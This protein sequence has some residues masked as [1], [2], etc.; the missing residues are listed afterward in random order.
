MKIT[1]YVDDSNDDREAPKK[2][3]L[4]LLT[5]AFDL[6]AD[7]MFGAIRDRNGNRVRAVVTVS[8]RETDSAEGKGS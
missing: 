5:S 4:R 8:E 3:A 2:L 6:D 7:E 1:L